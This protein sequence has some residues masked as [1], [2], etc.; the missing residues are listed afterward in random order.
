[1]KTYNITSRISAQ[2]RREIERIVNTHEKYRNAYFF[3]P[4]TSAS[5]R[6]RNERKFEVNNPDVSFQRG[7][8]II[9]VFMKYRESCNNVYYTLYVDS[10]T[11]GKKNINY[12]KSLLK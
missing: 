6:R 12:V 1:M 10:S 3:H 9:T 11:K 2:A 5:G 4:D 7:E 8:E